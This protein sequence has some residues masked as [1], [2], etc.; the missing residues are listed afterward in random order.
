MTAEFYGMKNELPSEEVFYE[1]RRTISNQRSLDPDARHLPT[2]AV[3]IRTKHFSNRND[4]SHTREKE[5]QRV[6]QETGMS[7][8]AQPS[9]CESIRQQSRR[10][11]QR[12]GD[13]H[14]PKTFSLE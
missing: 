1:S 11:T 2:L 8:P 5:D 4:R 13:L 3:F 14:G 10:Y 12:S 6:I 7:G 9:A